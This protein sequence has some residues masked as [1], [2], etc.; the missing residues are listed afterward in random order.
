MPSRW[1]SWVIAPRPS[2]TSGWT[3][4]P[5][6][7]LPK[8]G[9]PFAHGRA[10]SP[11][12]APPSGSTART[13][14]TPSP[15]GRACRAPARS[16]GSGSATESAPGPAPSPRSIRAD[17]ARF[18]TPSLVDIENP[19]QLADRLC[20]LLHRMRSLQAGDRLADGTPVPAVFCKTRPGSRRQRRR[21]DAEIV[22]RSTTGPPCS[23]PPVGGLPGHAS[24]HIRPG[25]NFAV[26][27][28]HTH[29]PNAGRAQARRL[30]RYA[31]PKAEGA[32]GPR[33]P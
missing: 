21:R 22:R 14:S 18:S 10:S 1:R 27:G 13:R 3:H 17:A 11:A 19:R 7:R 16:A 20:P 12:V 29:P 28:P 4:R 31:V 30:R 15:T 32:G 23:P 2:G 6:D 26:V 24:H 33:W 5:C 25:L 9:S 8:A